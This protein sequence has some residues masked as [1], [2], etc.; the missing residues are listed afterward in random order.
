MTK[1]SK[2]FLLLV[3]LFP[4]LIGFFVFLFVPIFASFYLSFTE[5]DILRKPLF[6]GFDNYMLLFSDIVFWKSLRVTFIY[7]FI[8]LPLSVVLGITFA[9][10]LNQK[11]TG[12][13][14][15]R[16]CLYLPSIIPLIA[17]SIIWLWIFRGDEGGLVN[18]FLSKLNISGPLWFSDSRW[19]LIPLIIMSLWSIG[20]SVLIYLAGLQDIPQAVYEAAD[21]D[22]ASFL[23]KLFLI[24]IPMLT[25]TIFFNLVIGI[26]SVFQYFIPA[27]VMTSGGPQHATTFYSLYAYQNAFEDFKLGYASSMAW[28]LFIIVAVLTLVAFR[29]FAGKVFYQ[30]K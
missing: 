1:I 30:G 28:I 18:H 26:I 21:I 24:T 19:A 27:Y 3:F 2:L 4:W 23:H 6:I 9:I 22:G 11:I 14:I 29:G 10:L 25:P 13:S 8:T 7:A 5:Y 17:S 16:T 12:I 20:N 15:Y